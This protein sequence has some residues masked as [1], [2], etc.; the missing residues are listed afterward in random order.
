[1]MIPELGLAQYL[2]GLSQEEVEEYIEQI[3]LDREQRMAVLSREAYATKAIIALL[4][5]WFWAI[6]SGTA[7]NRYPGLDCSVSQEKADN[8]VEIIEGFI[9]EEI[10]THPSHWAR[11][12]KD[13]PPDFRRLAPHARRAMAE[14][15]VEVF[16][17]KGG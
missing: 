7:N 3:A 17:E 5:E 14:Q 2:S 16:L 10:K 11:K 6:E 4:E 9:E 13:A 1:M 15:L 12:G 8:L